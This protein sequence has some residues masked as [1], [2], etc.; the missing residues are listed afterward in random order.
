MG[1]KYIDGLA[2]PENVDTLLSLF[3]KVAGARADSENVFDI[4]DILSNSPQMQKCLQAVKSD[5]AS[6]ELLDERYLGPELNLNSLLQCPKDSLGWTYAKVLSTMKYDPQFYRKRDINSDIDYITHRVRKTHDIH[7]ILTGFSFD[8]FGEFGV[9]SVLIGQIQ[10]PAAQV[11]CLL[12]STLSFI[13]LAPSIGEQENLEYLFNLIAQGLKISREAKPLF[14]VKFE[15]GLDRPIE[16]WRTELGIEP[17]RD[18]LWSWY[19][20]P[21]LAA[22]ITD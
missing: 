16:E 8:D 20:R 10:Y 6:A 1:F 14:P 12:G 9:V 19:S 18:G 17:V 15:E 11:M 3:D 22:A 13:S 4:E 2:T 5:P 7:H 21:D